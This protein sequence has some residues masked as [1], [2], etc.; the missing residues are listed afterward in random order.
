MAEDQDLKI[1]TAQGKVR[2]ELLPV[3]LVPFLAS[4]F[5]C[6]QPYM[7]SKLTRAA[8][9]FEYGS[10]KYAPWNYLKAK[11]D[12][13]TVLRYVGA[14]LRHFTAGSLEFDGESGLP[15]ICHEEASLLMLLHIIVRDMQDDLD[16]SA[17]ILKEVLHLIV[18]DAKILTSYF[19]L[20]TDR[21][22]PEY[23]VTAILLHSLTT[24][25]EILD[26]GAPNQPPAK[27]E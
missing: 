1:K 4:C 9:A 2:Y 19:W 3:H 11:P 12:Q 7:L 25:P 16:A 22:N 5:G 23:L 24:H 20:I 6:T 8:R 27:V 13:Q 14:A 18:Y 21:Y 15:H 26:P 17:P 10:M